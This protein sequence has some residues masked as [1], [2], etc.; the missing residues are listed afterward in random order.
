MKHVFLMHDVKRYHDLSVSINEVMKDY[1]YEIVYKTSMAAT[2]AYIQEC[3]EPC[4]FYAVGGDGTLSGIIQPLVHTHHELVVLPF[5]TGNDFCRTLTAQKDLIILLKES[6]KHECHKVDTILLNDRY[7]INSAC[8]GVDSV[9]ANHVHDVIQIPLVPQS[10]SYIVS[11]LQHVF[12][13]QHDEVALYSK[14]ECLYKGK[15]ILC[16][17]NNGQ[18]YGGG[19]PITPQADIQDGYFDVCIVDQLPNVKIPY[20]LSVLFKRQLHK[21]KEVH[22]F[23]LKEAQIICKNDC[24]LDGE[25]YQSHRYYF[26]IVPASLNIVIYDYH[27]KIPDTK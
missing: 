4:R 24:N 7:Y 2:I 11:I 26:Q 14:G 3:N 5:G 18:Y 12:S 9:I 8:F 23:R 17:L 13:Y 21:R 27:Q 25:Q 20:M 10:K 19:F 16:T 6:L 1:D 22:Y 15:V